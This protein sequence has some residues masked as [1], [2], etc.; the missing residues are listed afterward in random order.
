MKFRLVVK[1]FGRSDVPYDCQGLDGNSSLVVRDP[2][3]RV[4]PYIGGSFQTASPLP[5]PLL[6]P[7]ETAILFDGLDLASQY[8]IVKSGKYTVQFHGINDAAEAK[9]KE[10]AERRSSEVW[11]KR[12]RDK[13]DWREWSGALIP[14]SNSAV[15]EVQP[16]TVPPVKHIAARLLDVL[17]KEWGMSVHGYLG[18]TDCRPAWETTPPGWEARRPMPTLTLACPITGYKDDTVRA[19]LWIANSELRW[20]GK[21]DQP[22]QRAAVYLGKCPEGYLYADLPSHPEARA[23]KWPGLEKD[24]R[25]TLQSVPEKVFFPA[26]GITDDGDLEI[27][28]LTEVDKL[29]FAN[30][31]ITDV[32]MKRL[33]ELVKLKELWLNGTRVT[34]IGLQHLKGL[35]RLQVLA[36]NDTRITDAGLAHLK[37]LPRLEWMM[38]DDTQITDAGLAHLK[39]FPRLQSLRL[40]DTRITDRGLEHLKELSRLQHLS[41]RATHV[42]DA[43]VK[44]LQQALPNC[45]IYWPPPAK[46]QRQSP[47]APDQLR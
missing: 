19:S 1:N 17:P 27:E 38:L 13:F 28:K 42:T 22:G 7:G 39:E 32:G 3:G 6:A 18:E 33:A 8:L 11:G 26:D 45:E 10:Q 24:I 34:D 15:I 36:L 4:V 46:D 16:G 23:A 21:V 9:A 5:L 40:N 47:A 29:Y 14:T 2:Q 25:K 41:L 30:T 20:T 12:F 44:K 43:G 35:T 31:K 37:E